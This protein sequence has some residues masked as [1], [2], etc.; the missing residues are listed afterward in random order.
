MSYQA[1]REDV[2]YENRMDIDQGRASAGSGYVTA[3][4]REMHEQKEKLTSIIFDDYPVDVDAI[5]DYFEGLFSSDEAKKALEHLRKDLKSFSQSLQRSRLAVSDVMC[6]ID[7]LLASGLMNEEKRTTLKTF[8]ENNMVLQ[9]VTSV[10]NMRL[11]G[12]ELWA[13]PKEGILVEF[14]RHLNGKYR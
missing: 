8:K 9:E 5:N 1:P 13:W 7:G 3:G 14:R 11:V 2:A 6:A 4:R 10:L 12:L